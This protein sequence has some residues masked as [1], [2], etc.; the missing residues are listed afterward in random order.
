MEE[1]FELR[2]MEL[3]RRSCDGIGR[4]VVENE[5]DTQFIAAQYRATNKHSVYGAEGIGRE[6][7]V[8]I[9]PAE[10]GRNV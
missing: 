1:W 4:I 9:E 5:V 10:E 2:G 8:S 7:G 3:K 6:A